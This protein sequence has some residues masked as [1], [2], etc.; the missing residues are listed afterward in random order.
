MAH[1]AV[2]T[3]ENDAR[4]TVVGEGDHP[5]TRRPTWLPRVEHAL[6]KPSHARAVS[7]H[8]VHVSLYRVAIARAEVSVGAD[9]RDPLSVW[10][11]TSAA[12]T[13]GGRRPR[14]PCESCPI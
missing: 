11:P 10:R 3:H 6:R 12:V 9:E 4:P 5:S 2:G 7:V 1:P 8:D 13:P 14:Q